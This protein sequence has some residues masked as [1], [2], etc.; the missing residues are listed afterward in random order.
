MKLVETL[1][2]YLTPDLI[3]KVSEYLTESEHATVKGFNAAIPSIL[4]AIIHNSSNK[5]TMDQIWDLVTQMDN[6]SFDIENLENLF[7]GKFENRLENR[8]GS[9]LLEVLFGQR[10]Q[11]VIQELSSYAEFKNE[12]SASKLLNL[13]A[14]LVLGYLKKKALLEDYGISG[15]TMWL[16]SFK[17]EVQTSVPSS[18]FSLLNFGNPGENLEKITSAPT[19]EHDHSNNNWGMWLIGLLALL[20]FLWFVM[21]SCNKNEWNNNKESTTLKIDSTTIKT[22]DQTKEVDN[23][24]DGL[25]AKL[26]SGVQAKWAILGKPIKLSLPGGIEINIPE[27]GVEARLVN[28]IQDKNKGID[29]TTWFD[30]DRI[31]FE[32]GSSKLNPA[33]Q[34]QINNIT[35]ILKAFPQVNIKVGGYTDNVGDPKVNQKLSQARAEMV[36]S[37]LLTN[38]IESRRM[39]AEGYGQEHPVGDNKTE[40]GRDLNRRV[41]LRVT[42]K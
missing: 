15:L 10:F 34:I 22:A 38:G 18:L 4:G 19:Y 26:D 29:K 37:E 40:S 21:K 35:S 14:P 7:E 30:F 28:F 20:A 24:A 36:M 13:A 6:E 25:I 32:T 27:K 41:S 12:S 42:K 3:K 17:K 39:E 5:S 23:T 16:G 11:A 9:R 2:S 8:F 1:T 33:S 31:L